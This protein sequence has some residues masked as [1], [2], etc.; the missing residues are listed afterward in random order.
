MERKFTFNINDE[1]N[2]KEIKWI[3][4]NVLHCSLNIITKLKKGDFVI[5]NGKRATVREKTFSGDLLE[6]ILPSENSENILPNADINFKV[7]Y[8]D[9]DILAVDKPSGIPTH[10][11]INHYTDTLAN[12]V[13]NYF[14]NNFTFR[15]VNRLDR[16]TG[17]VVLIAKNILSAHILS[18]QLKNREIK[19]VYYAITEEVP[20]KESGTI[21]APIAREQESIIK[22]CVRQDGRYAETNYK[23]LKKNKEYALVMAEPVTGRTHQIRVH[24]SYIGCPLFGDRLYGSS[25]VN[26]RV[27][28]H[29][30]KLIFRHPISDETVMVESDIPPDFNVF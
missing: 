24:L 27:R 28:L 12:G 6:I 10:P 2:N 15:A 3:L 4:K 26:E 20:E 18:E 16:E 23:V 29:C 17:G 8:E 11:S 5:L 21:S 13:M 19:K 9:E 7:L 30:K 1:Y 14:G 25:K 22:R